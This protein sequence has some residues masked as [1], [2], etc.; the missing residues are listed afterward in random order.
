M[1][2]GE[3]KQ[4]DRRLLTYWSVDGL[5]E[6]VASL[7]WLLWGGLYL[8]GGTLFTGRSY[9]MYSSLLW[10][11]L[12]GWG[13]GVNWVM[14]KLKERLTYPRV[15]YAAAPIRAPG[16]AVYVVGALAMAVYLADG[17]GY[18]PIIPQGLGP[19]LIGGIV[20][21]AIALPATRPWT[22]H[23][24]WFF[25]VFL[26]MQLWRLQRGADYRGMCWMLV[27]MGLIGVV[28]GALRLRRFLREN[29]KAIAAEA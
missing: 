2:Q 21:V 3:L 26:G 17:Y 25:L 23:Q 5:P 28:F 6:L 24:A 1:D 20:A 7:G 12:W 11:G 19:V 13:F 15:G 22:A 16:F 8:M 9:R 4:I 18:R 27:C 10:P 29:P 14:G